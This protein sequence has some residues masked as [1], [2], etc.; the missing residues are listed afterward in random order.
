MPEALSPALLHWLAW[1]LG[2]GL[3]LVPLLRHWAAYR[4]VLHS[5]LLMVAGALGMLALSAIISRFDNATAS[6]LFASLARLLA[7][8]V[9]VRLAGLVL[10]RELLPRVGMRPAR[11]LE[12]VLVVAGYVMWGM[13]QLRDAGV[14]P[15]SLVTSSAVV[16]A[17]VAF[18]MQDTLGN[19]LGGLFLELGETFHRGDWVKIDD[20]SGRV[21]QIRWR[22]TAIR[23]RDGA[24]VIIPNSVL[25]RTRFLVL[26][27]PDA[28]A[29]RERRWIRFDVARSTPPS[30]VIA[31]VEGMFANAEVPNVLASPAPSCVLMDMGPAHLRFALRY[32]LADPGP[33]DPTDSAVRLLL[34]AALR[35]HDID[36]VVPEQRMLAYT[37]SPARVRAVEQAELERRRAALR[38]MDLFAALSEEEIA[39]LATRLVAAPFAAGEVMTREGAV[40]HW[41]Y[42]I[43]R[44]TADV[45][46]NVGGQRRSVNTIEAGGFFGEMALL[47]G[48]PRR[49]TVLARTDVECFRLDKA[50]FES[51]LRARPVLAEHLSQTLLRREDDL[52]RSLA[53]ASNAPAPPPDTRDSLVSRILGFFGLSESA[54]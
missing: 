12:D 15:S 46:V 22:H 8:W 4:E 47:T 18:A 6:A 7:G 1:A 44:G 16:T 17:V 26:G 25:M 38:R 50:S 45:V 5:T 51:I 21:E 23:T 43:D 20:L 27:D 48:A 9:L 35:R 37:D 13:A 53:S 32:W 14:D 49:A 36:L 39:T 3:L 52:T 33:D 31:L 28:G 40:A 11:I 41:L 54:S 30:E 2:A 10:F 29:G 19:L 42:L 24:L 34:L